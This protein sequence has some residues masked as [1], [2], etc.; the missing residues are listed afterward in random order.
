MA[1]VRPPRPDPTETILDEYGINADYALE[2][3]DRYRSDPALVDDDWREYF[4]D[5]TGPPPP[6]PAAPAPP[7]PAAAA[8]PLPSPT[9]PA[10]PAPAGERHPILGAALQIAQNMRASLEM[11]TA[12]SQRQVPIKLLEENRRLANDYRAAN[13]QSKISFTHVV[14]WRRCAHCTTFPD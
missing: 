12:T 2:L 7:P 8:P 6:V 1:T 5:L 10:E 14:A 3:F 13:D 4:D 9:R 11:P